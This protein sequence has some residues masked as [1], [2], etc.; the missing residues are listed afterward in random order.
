MQASNA[1]VMSVDFLLYV[2]ITYI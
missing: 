2:V 1:Q